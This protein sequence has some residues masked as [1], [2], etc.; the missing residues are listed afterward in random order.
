[1]SDFPVRYVFDATWRMLDNWVR[2]NVVPPHGAPLDLK[3]GDGPFVPDQAFVV[4]AYG[5]AKGGVRP[6]DVDV[7][8]A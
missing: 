4:N 1:M 7:S 3:P 2:N 8:T 5:N 6:P